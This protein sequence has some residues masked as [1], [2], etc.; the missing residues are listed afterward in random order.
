MVSGFLTPPKSKSYTFPPKIRVEIDKAADGYIPELPFDY[1]KIVTRNKEEGFRYIQSFAEKTS[2][3]TFH[4]MDNHDWDILNVTFTSTDRLQHFYWHDKR[5]LKTHY[6]WLDSVIGSM[7]NRASSENAD[8][9]LLSD[10]GFASIDKS[11]YPNTCLAKE[12]FIQAKNSKLDRLILG[13]GLNYENLME[14]LRQLHFRKTILRIS[15]ILGISVPSKDSISTSGN[16]IAR[17][18]TTSGLFMKQKTS[19]D[20]EDIRQ[21]IID[22]L[23]SLKDGEKRV[24]TGIYKPENILWGPYLSR[25]PDL[26]IIPENGYYLSTSI[27]EDIIGDP[28]QSSGLLRTGDHRM[29][30]IFS[31]YGPN[32]KNSREL[33]HNIQTWDIAPTILRMFDLPIRDYMDGQPKI[34]L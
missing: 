6:H 26:I 33:E 18:R 19:R 24:I 34:I 20:Y 23:I 12:G 25:A 32:I 14:L 9:I 8:V 30:G 5:L 7:L 21:R 31:A 13:V 15:R 11:V 10:H 28:I 3:A 16:S 29:Q 1:D 22:S 27:K 4:L 2:N 17:L